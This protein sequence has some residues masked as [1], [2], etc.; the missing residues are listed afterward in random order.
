MREYF[1]VRWEKAVA[2]PDLSLRELSLVEPLAVGF[3]AAARGRLAPGD[4]VTVIGCGA[5]G[6]GSLAASVTR[7]ATAIAIDLD[8]GKLE[9]ARQAGAQQVINSRSEAV[10]ERLLELTE[11]MGPDVVIE[12]VGTAATYVMAVEEVAHTGRVVYIGWS[13]EPVSFETKLFVH[14]ELDILGSRNY[15][16]EFPAVIELLANKQFPVEAS[17]SRTVSL[18]DAGEAL[19]EWSEEPQRFTKILVEVSN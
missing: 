3:H 10:H 17:I 16:G 2:A 6:L 5:V 4:V 14:K 9:L 1:T 8:D 12:A 7:G 18:T 13:K 15:L 11:G 19:R